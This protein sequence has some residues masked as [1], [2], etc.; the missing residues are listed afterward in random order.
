MK[1]NPRIHWPTE[2]LSW[3]VTLYIVMKRLAQS[4]T[5]PCLRL[6]N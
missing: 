1:F 6:G 4:I 5:K 3:I 2:I